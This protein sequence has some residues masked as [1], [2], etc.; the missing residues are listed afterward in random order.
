[1]TPRDRVTAAVHLL[2]RGYGKPAA[3][4]DIVILGKKISELST[5]ELIELNSR[6]PGVAPVSDAAESAEHSS[7]ELH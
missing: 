2:D 1:V 4:L 6:L 7:P 5:Q 3:S